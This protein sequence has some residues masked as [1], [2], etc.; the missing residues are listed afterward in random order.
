[1]QKRIKT[2]SDLDTLGVAVVPIFDHDEMIE[3]QLA[4][5]DMIF[6]EFLET[7]VLN[8]AHVVGAF[9]AL[10]NPSSFH[11]PTI[12]KLRKTVKARIAVALFQDRP[13]K[14]IES[15]FDRLCRREQG[16][17]QVAESWHQDLSEN[18]GND[19]FYGGWTNLTVGTVQSFVCVAGTQHVRHEK[20]EGFAPVPKE[21]HA[22]YAAQAKTIQVPPGHAIVFQQGIVHCI[23]PKAPL[24]TSLRLF[25]GFRI[26]EH[27][28]PKY[29]LEIVFQKLSV[30][31]LPSG[32]WPPMYSPN[33]VSYYQNKLESFGKTMTPSYRS[34]RGWP[35]V[36]KYRVCPALRDMGLWNAVEYDY[37]EEDKAV[38]SPQPVSTFLR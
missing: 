19:V 38:V 14:N 2:S 13:N 10:G 3:I 37:T 34:D 32:Q 27:G 35:L 17:K 23:N 26:T 31:P 18:A 7:D 28:E 8:K 6:P 1:M 24:R 4:V 21:F 9:G 5:D 12:R 30:P 22:R 29:P 36:G 15:M 25:H 33:H 16:I 11:H 20:M